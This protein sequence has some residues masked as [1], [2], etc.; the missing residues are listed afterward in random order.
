MPQ[1]ATRVNVTQALG[2]IKEMNL[3]GEEWADPREAGRAAYEAVVNELMKAQRDGYLRDLALAGG[4]DRRNGYYRRDLLTA[5]G[6]IELQVPRTRRFNARRVIARY[7]RR[8]PALDRVIL[9]AFVLGLSTRK[10]GVA[11]RHALGEVVSPTTVSRVARILDQAV[12]AY[13]R[14]PLVNRYRALIFDGVVLA[15]KSG[16]GALRRP[17]LVAL[18][19]TPDGKKEI[20]DFQL[21]RS[22]GAEAWEGFLRELYRRGLTGERVEIIAVD[23]GKG[24]RA[25][26]E[27]VYPRLRIQRC[28]AHKTRNI[29]D[30]VRTADRE[31]VKRQLQRIYGAPSLGHA[32]QAARAVVQRWR[33]RY[34]AAVRCLTQDLDE[35]LTFFHLKD[36]AWRRATR[37]TNAIERRFRE[38]RRRTRP[39]GTFSD[40]TSM[41]RILFAVFTHENQKEGIPSLLL[42]TQDV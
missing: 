11:L 18:G 39:M 21:A 32:R 2:V 31:C 40:R 30:Q 9:S 41:E 23:G 19:I 5:L 4:H 1:D 28:W 29:T 16:V 24:L 36:P 26:L 12:T 6:V 7:A 8:E 38:V 25:A 33:Q 22:E 20:I 13:H 42:L 34:P 14:R 3:W 35:L 27:V 17:V 15:R 37:T 10:V